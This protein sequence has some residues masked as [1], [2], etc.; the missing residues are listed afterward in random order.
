MSERRGRHGILMRTA[1]AA[2]LVA[3]G[4]LFALL[5]GELVLRLIGF[6]YPAF[7]V[8]DDVAGV[9]LRAGA[10][11]WYREEGE[12]HVRIN[13]NGWRDRERSEER[14]AHVVRV[15]LLGDSFMEAA[16][17]DLD[18]TF[19]AQLEREMNDCQPYGRSAVEVLNFGVSSYGTAQQLITL[20]E[21][22]W[23][24]AP[25]VVLLAF[26][27]ANDVR[28]N[29]RQL[30]RWKERPFFELRDGKLTLDMSFRDDPVFQEKLRDAPMQARLD[31]L[32]LYQLIRRVRDGAYQGWNDAPAAAAIAG[33]EKAS[34]SEAG[35]AER[36]YIPPADPG[37]REAWAI[38]ETLITAMNAEVKARRARFVVLVLPSAAAVYPDAGL[39][40]RYA[41]T[42]GV[43]DLFYPDGRIA[44]L[45]ETHGF[46]VIALGEPMQRRADKTGAYLHGF[47]NTRRGFG[48]WNARGHALAAQIVAERLCGKSR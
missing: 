34:L 17:V 22:V 27:P 20:R 2:A 3:G 16:Q 6:S 42:L 28:N 41:E 23:A 45:G 9:R 5:A 46:E 31:R 32:R 30:E 19:G 40:A 48:H 21:R 47:P 37:W 7:H 25:E 12:A 15:A 33:G 39:R 13:A 11:G 8:P 14:P 4:V 44:R 18:A 36:V 43:T 29:S 38:T 24:Y 26:L 10:E 1:A 35:I